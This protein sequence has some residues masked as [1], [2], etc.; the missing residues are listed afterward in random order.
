MWTYL[1]SSLILL[2]LKQRY[3]EEYRVVILYVVLT[4]TIN[5]GAN[6]QP[7]NPYAGCRRFT[8]LF[9]EL[10]D[11]FFF[12]FLEP[13]T[14]HAHNFCFSVNVEHYLNFFP[15]FFPAL[16]NFFFLFGILISWLSP[17]SSKGLFFFSWISLSSCRQQHSWLDQLNR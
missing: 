15:F 5:H 4:F 7:L 14:S 12:H 3:L 10:D 17:S 16:L 8:L 1:P 11:N 6:F 2:K 9:I 13:M